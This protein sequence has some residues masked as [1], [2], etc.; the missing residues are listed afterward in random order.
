MPGSARSSHHPR[1]SHEQEDSG[2]QAQPQVQ[3]QWLPGQCSCHVGALPSSRRHP[4]RGFIPPECP[5]S[6]FSSPGAQKSGSSV[7]DRPHRDSAHLWFFLTS[8]PPPSQPCILSAPFVCL[9]Q[10]PLA[11]SPTPAWNS[12]IGS[13]RPALSPS[14]PWIKVEFPVPV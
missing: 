3:A 11:S 10:H 6:K 4:P 5:E 13:C 2:H 8:V 12:L 1:V 9:P 14:S 7:P